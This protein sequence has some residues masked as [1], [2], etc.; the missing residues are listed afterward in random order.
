MNTYLFITKPDEHQPEDV[1]HGTESWWSCSKTTRKRDRALVFVTGVGVAYEWRVTSDAAR[2][3]EWKYICDVEHVRTFE[4]PIHIREI[5]EVIPMADWKPPYTN[6]RGFKSLRVPD[7]I[8]ERIRSIRNNARPDEPKTALKDDPFTKRALQIYE[9]ANTQI[10]YPANRFRQKVLRVGGLAA[11]KDWL[12]GSKMTEGF[13][14]LIEHDRLDLSL[15]AVVLETKWSKYFTGEELATARERLT[16]F[17]YFER[18]GI[19]AEDS[20]QLSAEELPDESKFPEGA[21]TKITVSA[22]ER[23]PEARKKCIE[24]YKAICY[25]CRF[26]FAKVYG[27]LGKEFIHVHHLTPFAA[28]GEPRLT[29]PIADL[30]PVCPNC[31]SMLHRRNPPIPIAELQEIIRMNEA[32]RRTHARQ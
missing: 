4:R 1:R 7:A 16:R 23:N 10:R 22:Y 29:D 17:G 14:R 25:A 31:H 27:D 32:N 2:N 3:N 15:E 24:H 30:R 11:A 20:A 5:R 18:R 8:A 6:F 26:K 13:K 12:K 19:P 28:R 21:K 9:D